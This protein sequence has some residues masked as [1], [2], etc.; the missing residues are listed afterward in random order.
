VH[1]AVD[2]RDEITGELI[3]PTKS[4]YHKLSCDPPYATGKTRKW[5]GF[6]PFPQMRTLDL[7]QKMQ[8]DVERLKTEYLEGLNRTEG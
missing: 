8:P 2:G 7:I 1:D 5:Y 6:R 4:Q 3:D